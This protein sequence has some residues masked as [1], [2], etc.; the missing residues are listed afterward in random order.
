VFS[1]RI[2]PTLQN[3]FIINEY[4]KISIN[5][6]KDSALPTQRVRDSDPT[7]APL[8]ES[9]SP[10]RA[11]RQLRAGMDLIPAKVIHTQIQE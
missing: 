9:A 6:K 3:N 8:T 7:R 2:D 5:T 1:R 4:K 10:L 11:L